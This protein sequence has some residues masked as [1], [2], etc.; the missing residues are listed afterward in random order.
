MK[1]LDSPQLQL[2]PDVQLIAQINKE[3]TLKNRMIKRRGLTL[4]AVNLIKDTCYKVKITSNVVIGLDKKVITEH[5]AAY[6]PEVIYMWAI[7]E[8]RAVYKVKRD[9]NQFI[10]NQ[11]ARRNF[12]ELKR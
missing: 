3:Y 6:D 7:N 4:F 12:N 5:K 1:E 10:R 11:E 8:E 2:R 9:F